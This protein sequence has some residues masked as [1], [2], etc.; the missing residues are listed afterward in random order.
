LRELAFDTDLIGFEAPELVRLLG[1]A[2]AVDGEEEVPD[3][4]EAPVSRAGDLWLLG[5]HRL[6]C[7]DATCGGDVGRL[8]GNVR[9][10]LMVTDRVRDPEAG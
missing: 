1:S 2:E 8:L 7:G 4:P 6:L 9:P 10:H 3:A 5:R